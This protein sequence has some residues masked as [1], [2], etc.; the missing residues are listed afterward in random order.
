MTFKKLDFSACLLLLAS[1]L[2]LATI[3]GQNAANPGTWQYIEIDSTKQMWGDWNEPEWLRYFGLD[4]G[5][6]DRDGNLDIISGRY[7]YHN[8]GGTMQGHWKRTVL[9]DNVDAILSL[10]V[11]GDAYADIIAMSLP[12]LFWYEAVNTEGT[13]YKRKLIGQ[14]PATSHVNS[15]GFEKAQIIAGGLSEFVIAGNGD[16]YAV[17]IPEKDADTVDWKVKLICKNTSDE[18]IGVGDID[19]DGDLDIAAGR[20]PDG[21]EEPKI[22][23]W[24]ENPGTIDR[25]WKD[26]IVRRSQHPIDRIEVADV[27]GDAKADIICTEERYPGEEPDA[28]FWWFAQEGPTQWKSNKITS[29]YSINNLDITDFDH[30]GD[31]DLLTAEHKG[32]TLELQLWNNDGKGNFSKTVIDTGKENHLGT[33][34]ADLD[35]DG[36]LDIIGAGWDQHRF[37][38]VWRNDAVKSMGT[39]MLFKEHSWV[40][41][42]V[43]DSGKFLRV[44]GK[45]GYEM[46]KDHFPADAHSG[47]MILLSFDIDLKNATAAEV[48]VERVQSHEDTKNLRIQFNEGAPIPLP[49]PATIPEPATDYMFHTNVRV[50]VPVTTLNEGTTNAFRLRV[51]PEQSWNWPQNIIYGITLRIYYTNTSDNAVAKIAGLQD[52]DSLGT[53][54]KLS[55]TG[56]QL[57]KIAKVEYIGLYEDVN[58]QGDGKYRQWQYRY[59]RALLESHIGTSETAPFAVNWDTAWIPDQAEPIKITARVTRNNGL[60]EILAPVD[61]LELKRDAS[62]ALLKPYGQPPFWTTRNKAYDEYLNVPFEPSDTDTAKLYWN[63]WSPCY[64]EGLTINGDILTANSSAPCYDAFLHEESVTDIGVLKKGI[65]VISTMKTPKHDGQMVH[66]MDV[67]WPGIMLKIKRQNAGSVALEITEA[68]YENRP[69]YVITT[70]SATYYFDKA[71][72]GF[73]RIIDTYGN[74]WVGYRT[75]PWDTYPASAASAYRGLPN[76]VFKSDTDGGAGHPGHDKCISEITAD[77]H[78]RTRTKSG[79]W[80]WEWQFS[81]DTALLKVLKAE[82]DT[83]YWFLY[84][85]TPGGAYEPEAYSY[86]TNVSESTRNLPDFYKG[87][88]HYDDFRWAYFNRD[89]VPITFFTAQLNDA[90]KTLDMMAYLGNSEEGVQ[91]KNGM[92]VFGFG[93]GEDTQ[94]LLTGPNTFIIGFYKGAVQNKTGHERIAEHINTNIQ[95]AKNELQNEEL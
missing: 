35:N 94:P 63:S 5:D 23:V 14:V 49:E 50:P 41:E 59:H 15:Q 74:D 21:E 4:A 9:D 77:N 71:G 2:C 26:I 70:K 60:I 37:M 66:G 83:P 88:I 67:Q 84:E 52:G 90:E 1:L 24:Y 58:L 57:S 29:Q 80:E 78:I 36:D 62:V 7:V 81:D 10:D 44:G 31:I 51:D 65:N 40:P 48:I 18:G 42:K 11:D 55:L 86:G 68:I 22:L 32:P 13:R 53:E 73:S 56:D 72:G 38:H 64:S 47:G 85:G 12:D 6:V 61:G 3:Q 33:Q 16:I 69:H 76:L 39:G 82:P 20:R 87:D 28:N 92:T 95:Q 75:E 79:L 8:P 25:P 34:W 45:A 43:S 89:G 93:R 17:A 91:S 30:D 19:G 27:N 54:V 46:D